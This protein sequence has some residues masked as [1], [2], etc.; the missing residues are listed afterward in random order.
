VCRS[1]SLCVRRDLQA[2][3]QFVDWFHEPR[4]RTPA[5]GRCLMSCRAGDV[6]TMSALDGRDIS[7]GWTTAVH[8]RPRG[9]L[10]CCGERKVLRQRQHDA[11]LA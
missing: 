5:G 1:A 11:V 6:G 4:E 7:G 9:G 2:E 3:L 8:S 10:S